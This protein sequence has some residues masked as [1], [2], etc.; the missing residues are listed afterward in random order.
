MP[1]PLVNFDG[2]E[3]G[4]GIKNTEE[5]EMGCSGVISIRCRGQGEDKDGGTWCILL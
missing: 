3:G 1:T 2:E 5:E 4:G